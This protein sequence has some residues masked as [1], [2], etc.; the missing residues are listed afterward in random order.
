MVVTAFDSCLGESGDWLKE[1]RGWGMVVVDEAHRLKNHD[2]KLTMALRDE[3]YFDHCVL[4]TG[5]PL[6]NNTQELWSI[7]NFIGIHSDNT[8]QFDS[9]EEFCH[10]CVTCRCCCCCWAALVLRPPRLLS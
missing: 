2:S 9:M 10:K 6:Q 7:L 4:M 1:I 3:Y 8:H 5:T